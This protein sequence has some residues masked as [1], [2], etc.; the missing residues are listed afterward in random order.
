MVRIQYFNSKPFGFICIAVTF[1][2]YTDKSDSQFFDKCDTVIT[3]KSVKNT[4]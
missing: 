1:Y 2:K 3:L 4:M